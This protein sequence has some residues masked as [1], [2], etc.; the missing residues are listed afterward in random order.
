MKD[1][2]RM[3][4]FDGNYTLVTAFGLIFLL[5]TIFLGPKVFRL[6]SQLKQLTLAL[7]KSR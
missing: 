4:A 1:P 3:Y 2:R 5:V 6:I 7:V